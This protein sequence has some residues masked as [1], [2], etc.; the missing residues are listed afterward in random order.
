MLPCSFASLFNEGIDRVSAGPGDQHDL[1]PV[2]HEPRVAFRPYPLAI[3]WLVETSRGK[4][5]KPMSKRLAGELMDAAKEEGAAFK[6]KEDV[7]KM[8]EANRAFAHYARY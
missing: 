3:R 8:A 6:K 5:G 2:V 1:L 4:K 7:H